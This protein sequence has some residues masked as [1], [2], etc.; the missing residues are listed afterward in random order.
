MKTI[1]DLDY[2]TVIMNDDGS[3]FYIN[4]IQD[5]QYKEL[6][7][8][9]WKTA[10]RLF[11][12][13][14]VEELKFYYP[15]A[16]VVDLVNFIVVNIYDS[17]EDTVSQV[18]ISYLTKSFSEAIFSNDAE[19]A[20]AFSDEFENGDEHARKELLSIISK[21]FESNIQYAAADAVVGYAKKL[22]LEL[23]LSL[24]LYMK[25]KNSEPLYDQFSKKFISYVIKR[26]GIARSGSTQRP[27]FT[28]R[29][30]DKMRK[31]MDA[32][33]KRTYKLARDS[34]DDSGFDPE[35]THDIAVAFAEHF[36]DLLKSVGVNFEFNPLHEITTESEFEFAGAYEIDDVF[37]LMK[38]YIERKFDQKYM[39]RWL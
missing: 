20:E 39:L 9:M 17:N 29:E 32:I 18:F 10:Y 38:Q 28:E 3:L 4:M 25:N 1:I 24:E 27:V 7:E 37:A 23:S 6:I 30:I 26:Y 22:S 31:K 14:L 34:F 2:E 21:R 13:Y 5:K 12:D 35:D 11:T 16:D 15:G 8:N 36:Y 19:D 33:V